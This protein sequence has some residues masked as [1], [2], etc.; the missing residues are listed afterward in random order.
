CKRKGLPWI[1]AKGFR[2]SCP[3]SDFMPKEKIPD[4]HKLKIWLKMNGKLR[5]EGE[6]SSMT[7][8]IPYL[9]SYISKI[10]TLEEGD[11]ILTGCPEGVGSVQA[12]SEIEAGISD[13]LSVWFKVAQQKHR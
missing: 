11:L 5:Q 12:S 10:V 4:L 1:L 7:F 3:V 6:T 9:M 13:V 2:L 8:S